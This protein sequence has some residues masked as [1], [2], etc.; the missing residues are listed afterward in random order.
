MADITLPVQRIHSYMPSLQERVLTLQTVAL[1]EGG[2]NREI[3]WQ[4]IR[5]MDAWMSGELGGR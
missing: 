4:E 3:R 2:W 5:L 1:G